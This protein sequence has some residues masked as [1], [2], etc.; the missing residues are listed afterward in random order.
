MRANLVLRRLQAR[1]CVRVKSSARG[2]LTRLSLE[3]SDERPAPLGRPKRELLSTCSI[4]T[5]LR[6]E[7]ETQR[8]DAAVPLSTPHSSCCCLLCPALP[9]HAL[10]CPAVHRPAPPCRCEPL[11]GPPGGVHQLGCA[12]ACGVQVLRSEVRAGA[13]AQPR[14]Q[15][16]RGTH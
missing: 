4:V 9:F 12:G 14:A 3:R 15:P 13:R 8:G 10:P 7:K 1:A 16:L 6:T 5:V 11:A 2:P